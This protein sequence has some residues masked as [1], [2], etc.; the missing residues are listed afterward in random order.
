MYFH[1]KPASVNGLNAKKWIT[2]AFNFI[3]FS[4][5]K[6][7]TI[8]FIHTQN[9]LLR[10]IFVFTCIAWWIE[11]DHFEKCKPSLLSGTTF[12]YI[13][14]RADA[15]DSSQK[16][17]EGN[18]RFLLRV[19]RTRW[20]LGLTLCC[21]AMADCWKRQR[22]Y[23]L[24]IQRSDGYMH[25][26]TAVFL[27]NRFTVFSQGNPTLTRVTMEHFDVHHCVWMCVCGFT[28]NSYKQLC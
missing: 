17:M 27:V 16:Q 23:E 8:L 9:I 24:Y 2:K 26:C 11:E 13:E 22:K 6:I 18:Y 1:F 20:S 19:F 25:H 5:L 21:D 7:Y 14:K 15:S 10:M 3:N 4:P 12:F 28:T